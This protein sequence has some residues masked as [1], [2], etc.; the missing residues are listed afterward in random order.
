MA[1]TTVTKIDKF[2]K[3]QTI[4]EEI[5][6]HNVKWEEVPESLQKVFLNS[7][8]LSVKESDN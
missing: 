6:G 1:A 7:K 3:F 4:Y 5:T 8:Q 2:N